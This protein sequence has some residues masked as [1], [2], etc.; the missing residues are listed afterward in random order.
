MENCDFKEALMVNKKEVDT[1]LT[2]DIFLKQHRYKKDVNS[3]F[4]HTEMNTCKGAYYIPDNDYTKFI[5]LYTEFIKEGYEIGLVERH[6]GCKVGPLICDFDFRSRNENRSYTQEHIKDIIKLFV[7]VITTNF[8]I[9]DRNKLEAFVYEKE[10]PTMDKKDKDIQWK[11]GFH[12]FFPYLPLLVEYRF[13]VYDII[14]NKLKEQKILDEIPS[15]EP[16]SEVYD[17]SIIYRNGIMMYGSVKPGRTPYELT[18]VYNTDLTEI[19]ISLFDFDSKINTSLLRTYNDEDSI[20]LKSKHLIN[21]AIIISQKN[22][23]STQLVRFYDSENFSEISIDEK[24]EILKQEK[25]QQKEKEKQL[26]KEEK[27]KKNEIQTT[28]IFIAKSELERYEEILKNLNNDRFKKYDDWIRIGL[29][30]IRKNLYDLFDMYSK[31]K[32]PE[33]YNKNENHKIISSIY[34]KEQENEP[35]KKVTERTLMKWLKI[36]NEEAYNQIYK[37]SQE[38]LNI[39]NGWA[40]PK[41]YSNILV[42]LL[43]DIFIIEEILTTDGKSI[44]KSYKWND[45]YW[46][47]CSIDT[48][49]MNYISTNLIKVI[50][51]YISKVSAQN[52]KDK[53]SDSLEAMSKKLFKSYHHTKR[54]LETPSKMKEIIIIFRACISKTNIEWN[55]NPKLYI[56]D[57]AVYDLD[58]GEF[59]EP[60]KED[61]MN[62]SCGYSYDF[63]NSY[64]KEI[65]IIDDFYSDCLDKDC[66]E[67]L[68]IYNSSCLKRYNTDQVALFNT[69]CGGNG[70]GLN[71][72]L[73][74]QCLGNYCKDLSM[75]Y[76]TTIERHA[77]APNTSLA[78][79]RNARLICLA[80]A[81]QN[82]NENGVKIK[83]NKSKFKKCTGQDEI[84]VRPT[85]EKVLYRFNMG[86]ICLSTNNIPDMDTVC[87]PAIL[88]RIL[89]VS[90]KFNY[91]DNPNPNNKNEKKKNAELQTIFKTEQMRQA[92]IRILFSYYDIYRK[93]GLKINE[94]VKEET[95]NILNKQNDVYNCI[96]DMIEKGILEKDNKERISFK[97]LFNYYCESDNGYKFIS[98]N[99]FTRDIK[100]IFPNFEY[101]EGH[102]REM[103]LCKYKFVEDKEDKKED[104]FAKIKFN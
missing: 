83:I 95:N 86:N 16:L 8:N 37:D 12:I 62:L 38:I 58:K 97:I 25:K 30:C 91:V 43:D 3:H 71:I 94:K 50:N 6:D 53:D 29:I 67:T 24:I 79:C 19:D 93:E 70:K 102:A 65:K 80:E 88:R 81:E 64:E 27:Q 75:D 52:I 103:Y 11:D 21:D 26:K 46:E 17:P 36:D 45:V 99:I 5:E 44:Q 22:N 92:Y 15:I 82:E 100:K 1:A 7:E 42:D 54:D 18:H 47:L 78:E 63:K 77:D 13:L 76:F 96:Q 101:I 61:Y 4:T 23:Y 31:I 56:F 57:N 39:C 66:K 68:L 10:S 74:K 59:I 32:G 98:K 87:D 34:K 33:K 104:K 14:L 73:L 2:F 28:N 69:G 41:D 51:E 35:D 89:I 55:K 48:F 40:S 85:F 20:E 9:N 90:F 72:L 60:K 84:M 49:L